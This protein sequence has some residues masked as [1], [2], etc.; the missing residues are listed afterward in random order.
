MP[1]SALKLGYP[2]A[3]SD[4]PTGGDAS[5][6]PGTNGTW[7]NFIAGTSGSDLAFAAAGYMEFPGIIG[8]GVAK[9][10]R[11]PVFYV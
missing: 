2:G 1:T 5:S 4:T 9:M 8:G 11:V 7:A 6:V 10:L 3:A